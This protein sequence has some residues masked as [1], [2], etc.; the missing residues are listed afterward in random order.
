[1]LKCYLYMFI[2]FSSLIYRSFNINVIL[3]YDVSFI[4]SD[5]LSDCCHICGEKDVGQDENISWVKPVL[6][7]DLDFKMEIREPIVACQVAEGI[8][9]ASFTPYKGLALLSRR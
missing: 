1:M 2:L 9:S 5:D 7:L 6:L 8:Q 4:L 3:S